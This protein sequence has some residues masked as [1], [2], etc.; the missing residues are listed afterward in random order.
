[1]MQKSPR[2]VLAGVG[3]IL[4]FL[5]AAF[6]ELTYT[7]FFTPTVWISNGIRLVIWSIDFVLIMV[8]LFVTHKA[9]VKR[10]FE[11]SMAFVL[12]IAAL[13]IIEAMFFG[14]YT[15]TR[16]VPTFQGDFYAKGHQSDSALGYKPRPNSRTSAM[17]K[18][19]GEVSYDISYTIDQHGRRVT[20]QSRSYHKDLFA[21]FFGCSYTFGVGVEDNQTLPFYFSQH[22]ARHRVYNYGFGG[23]GPHQMLAQLERE[24]FRSEIKENSGIGVYTFIDHHVH[25]ANGTSDSVWG[26]G[27]EGPFYTLDGSGQLVRH[28]S[29]RSGRPVQSLLNYSVSQSYVVK[30]FNAS[31]PIINEAHFELT[32]RIVEK[33]RDTFRAKFG[34]DEFYVLLFPRTQEARRIIPRLEKAH[35]K[36]LDY[37]GLFQDRWKQFKI[38]GDGHPTPDAYRI[39]AAKLANDIGIAGGAPF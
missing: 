22:A 14:L 12:T 11:A 33:A 17:S 25:R 23:Y 9:G 36:Y 37:S 2:S 35:V 38:P 28:G 16:P 6:N 30:Y 4:I 7:F 10:V 18:L 1:M 26:L 27:W 21:L 20:P 13:L 32:A 29:F 19:N 34:S 39:V 31:I 8:G 5:V 24:D 3:L 15:V